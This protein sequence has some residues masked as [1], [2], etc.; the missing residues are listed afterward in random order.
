MAEERPQSQREA[1]REQNVGPVASQE[2]SVSEE[3]P[4]RIALRNESEVTMVDGAAYM[5]SD[6]EEAE[7]GEQQESGT[8]FKFTLFGVTKVAVF[9]SVGV[10]IMAT[11]AVLGINIAEQ[12]NAATERGRTK[13]TSAAPTNNKS[14]GEFYFGGEGNVKDMLSHNSVS[15]DTVATLQLEPASYEPSP[16]NAINSSV[17][18]VTLTPS[19]ASEQD[20][21]PGNSGAITPVSSPKSIATESEDEEDGSTSSDT[22][23]ESGVGDAFMTSSFAKAVYDLMPVVIRKPLQMTIGAFAMGMDSLY[24]S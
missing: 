11:E 3:S 13:S 10:A 7:Y 6:Q 14:E 2:E 5:G 8:P 24:G 12:L 23:D 16:A 17:L 22:D 1:E 19:A 9:C 4:Q 21:G 18:E 15:I 20:R